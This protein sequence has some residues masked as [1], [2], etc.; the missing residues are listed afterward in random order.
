MSLDHIKINPDL[1]EK[2]SIIIKISSGT[3]NLNKNNVADCFV[4][5]YKNYKVMNYSGQL[6]K[7]LKNEFTNIN[8]L[9]M[10][11]NDYYVISKVYDNYF[12]LNK[13][14]YF[15]KLFVKSVS[16]FYI[17]LFKDIEKMLF[18]DKNNI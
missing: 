4:E 15:D 11:L 16:K 17:N 18:T 1:F 13:V 10:R 6:I 9:S 7:V 14:E 2:L 5:K 12:N 3:Y 8:K